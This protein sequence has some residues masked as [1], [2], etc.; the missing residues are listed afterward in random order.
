MPVKFP[1]WRKRARTPPPNEDDPRLALLTQNSSDVIMRHSP[2]GI[3][4]VS[5][6]ARE[7]FGVEPDSM[8][9]SRLRDYVIDED[10]AALIADS[11]QMYRSG[12]QGSRFRFRIRH[13]SGAVRWV[14]VNRKAEFDRAGSAT[15]YHVT[16]LRDVT[17]TQ[18]LEQKLAAMALLDG[19]TGI[20][21]RRAFDEALDR[22]WRSA[23]R[24]QCNLSLLLLDIDHFKMFNDKYGHQ[25]GDDC[26]RDVARAAAGAVKRPEDFVARYGGEELAII[27][28][29][30]DSTGA[31]DVAA[32]ILGAIRD[33]KI[34]HEPNWEGGGFA[35]AS[36]GGATA[37]MYAG[38]MSCTP[39]L[40]LRAADDALY[41]AKNRG[42]NTV[43]VAPT[44]MVAVSDEDAK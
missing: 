35:S 15:G 24:H 40:L 39:A 23:A 36:I 22:C 11:T 34:P 1:F 26:L 33:L 21:N 14:E 32:R 8:L 18:E 2:A 3:T 4:Y 12:P 5:P 41:E 37:V 6:A 28:P 9:G 13:A 19:L 17:E 10:R 20:A 31:V 38:G 42:R 29:E 30:T 44:M 27:L 25:A 43:S 7:I 16:V